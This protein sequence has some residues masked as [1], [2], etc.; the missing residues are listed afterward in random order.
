MLRRRWQ[1]PWMGTMLGIIRSGRVPKGDQGSEILSDWC[2]CV[3]SLQVCAPGMEENPFQ[4]RCPGS[5]LPGRCQMRGL[6]NGRCGGKTQGR[7][8]TLFNYLIAIEKQIYLT[9]RS[10]IFF[11]FSK[12]EGI[13]VTISSLVLQTQCGSAMCSCV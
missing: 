2:C 9:R 11:F 1:H 10:P 3:Q 8:I 4:Q 6:M 12:C 7:K 5:F 13:F